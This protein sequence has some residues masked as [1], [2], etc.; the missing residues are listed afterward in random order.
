MAN[1]NCKMCGGSIHYNV[2]DKVVTCDFCGSTQ[3]IS[4]ITD[5]RKINLFNRANALRLKNEFD[6]ALATY[7][8]ILLEFPDDAEAHWGLCLCKYG[9]EYVNDPKT[10]KKIPTCHRTLYEN[11]LD[12][13]DYKEAIKNSDVVSRE[14]YESEAKT[15]DSIQKR[16]I[17][18]SQR[19]EPYDIFICYKETDENGQR[20]TDSVM[21]QDI[22]TELTKKGYKVFFSRI[23][24]EG[25]IGTEY[26]P[27]IFAALRSS[28]VM[29]CIANKV[30]YFNSPWVKNE[31]SRYLSFMKDS[32]DKYLIPC[33][34]DIDAYEL[35]EEMM[36][37]QAQDMDKIGAIQDLLRGIDKL[38]N[39][40]TIITEVK[41]TNTTITNVNISALLRRSEML[42]S[43]K[44]YKKAN[45][46]L[47]EVLNNDP[48]N[49]KAYGLLATIDLGFEK[50]S[51]LA[52]A[53][54]PL[55]NNNNYKYALKFADEDYKSQLK[56]YNDII[57]QRIKY[58][59]DL[60]IYQNAISYKE[61]GKY[62]NA[63]SFFEKVI[64]FK[65]SKEQIEMCN[66][67]IFERNNNTYNKACTLLEEYKYSE[68]IELFEKI[69]AF[70]DAKKQFEI[71]KELFEKEKIY[72]KSV[73][74]AS[75]DRIPYYEKAISSLKTIIDYRD[76]GL[77]VNTYEK[78]IDELKDELE[79]KRIKKK[80]RTRIFAIATASLVLMILLSYFIIIPGT[81][82][83]IATNDI[84]KG[85]YE[86][87]EQILGTIATF[88]DSKKQISLNKAAVE[89]EHNNYKEALEA[90]EKADGSIIV[91]YNTLGGNQIDDVTC[92]SSTDYDKSYSLEA[93]KA[94][95]IFEGW[96]IQEY[97]V[98][99][100]KR[101]INLILSANYSLINYDIN[102]DLESGSFSDTDDIIY[103]YDVESNV[104]IPN[105]IRVGY[106]FIG[107]KIND[108]KET[109]I[110]YTIQAGTCDNQSLKAIWRAN[111][112]TLTY[113]P[114]GGIIDASELIVDYDSNFTTLIPTREGYS[115]GGWYYNGSQI[116]SGIWN[117]E[118]N[119]TLTARWTTDEFLINYDLNGGI[120][121]SNNASQYTVEDE[122]IISSPSKKGYTFI[123]WTTLGQNTPIIETKIEKGS[124]GD[125]TY[126]ANWQAN[127]YT[128]SFNVN[129]NDVATIES[130]NVIF[131][132][133][134][135]L[136]A[137]NRTGYIFDG[138][139]NGNQKVETG[140]WKKAENLTLTAKWQVITYTISYNLDGGS[141]NNL[142]R[143]NYTVEDAFS[144]NVPEKEGY[145]FLG[146]T[147]SNNNNLQSTISISKGTIGNIIVSANWSANTYNCNL[148]VNS[149][150]ELVN[151]KFSFTFDDTYTLPEPTKTGYVFSGWYNGDNKVIGSTWKIA[152]N[153]TLIAS[154]TPRND[155]QYV[156]NHFKQNIIDDEFEL[157][158][159]CILYGVA[160]SNIKALT[161]DYFG[162][163]IPEANDV[164]VKADGSLVVDY[165][166][167]RKSYSISFVCNGGSNISTKTL[168][169]ETSLNQFLTSR[170]DY[171][172]G[173][174]YSDINLSN[175]VNSIDERVA[176]S[177][178]IYAWWKE[179]TK[180]KSFNYDL[181]GNEYTITGFNGTENHVTIPTYIDDKKVSRINNVSST[182]ITELIIPN[183]IINIDKGSLLCNNLEKL[184]TPFTGKERYSSTNEDQNYLNYAIGYMFGENSFYGGVETNQN[185]AGGSISYYL[186]SSLSEVI[187]ADSE[188]ITACSFLNC[189]YIKS[190]TITN[191]TQ[192]I[193]GVTFGGC[194]SLEKL[195]IPFI[196]NHALDEEIVFGSP[197]GSLFGY[198]TYIEGQEITQ[199]YYNQNTSSST[200]SKFKI[201]ST[202]KEITITGD[203]N[204]VSCAFYNCNMIEKVH[205]LGS[206]KRIGQN[207]FYG[208]TCLTSIDLPSDLEWIYQ[209]CF[210]NCSSLNNLSLPSA[211][212]HLQNRAFFGCKSLES[213]EL[214]EDITNISAS[215]FYDCISLKKMV[216]HGNITSVETNAFTNCKLDNVTAPAIVINALYKASL[217]EVELISYDGII[218]EDTFASCGNLIRIVIPESVTYIGVRAFSG[219]SLLENIELPSGLKTIGDAAF[220]RCS[221]LV[222]IDI[223]DSVKTIGTNVFSECANLSKMRLPFIGGQ[224]NQSDVKSPFGYIFGTSNANSSDSVSQE[225]YANGHIVSGIFNIPNS[226][227]EVIITNT[228]NIPYGAFSGCFN[229]ESISI[230][231]EIATIEN[232]AF[233]GCESLTN[234]IIPNSITYIGT[235]AFEN[236][237]SLSSI[238][239][240]NNVISIGDEA[241]KNCES[242][243]EVS[244]PDSLMLLGANVFHNCK[245]LTYVHLSDNLKT[246]SQR[247]F[248]QCES[249]T[250]I[251]LNYV[252]NI[253]GY[254]F[255]GCT[256]LTDIN[257]ESVN[258]IYAFAF[259]GCESLV[260]VIAEDAISVEENA[261]NNCYRLVR[262]VAPKAQVNSNLFYNCSKMT[263][264]SIGS[265]S[266]SGVFALFY[267]FGKDNSTSDDDWISDMTQ[268]NSLGGSQNWPRGY[269]PQSLIAVEFDRIPLGS[270]D[271]PWKYSCLNTVLIVCNEKEQSINSTTIVSHLLYNGT[272]S[273]Y[274]TLFINNGTVRHVYYYSEEK[275]AENAINYWHY[276]SDEIP[277]LYSDN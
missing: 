15:I 198:S 104:H 277:E 47:D 35:P 195:S 10:G 140:I 37:F 168:K 246:I 186:P 210:E 72:L 255:S 190:I 95:Y 270:Y 241:F 120:N 259:S 265:Y 191:N 216:V 249:L 26:E 98:T 151:D 220:N 239:M 275:P 243:A 267:L 201:P 28:K 197:L 11:I 223:P 22:Y 91:S 242:L 171:S 57:I 203:G 272:Q 114:N 21:A 154:W 217:K 94:G 139:Y 180:T 90:I 97:D 158:E 112:Y 24:L 273:E 117:F 56:K 228:D 225:F 268:D 42:I 69:L 17:E 85:N 119:I 36:A 160:D 141:N 147:S 41:Q 48:E 103:N 205:I 5:E 232:K 111:S 258:K 196:G 159:I 244:M 252:E 134:Y 125:I 149:G 34:R 88:S 7:E 50:E 133:A 52:K 63:I 122:V 172:F 167:L 9:I 76:S 118:S 101:A 182:N 124:V 128:L 83:L 136:P 78:R 178:K 266:G 233:Y 222:S 212:N 86:A 61:S 54:E 105:P 185:Y 107:W 173:G 211:V 262:F 29:L 187:V 38:F 192:T 80:K 129:C 93:E 2:G 165:Y 121:N 176:E 229:I 237:K 77:L 256:K 123:G 73:K 87:A 152:D 32:N 161:M 75:L 227:K 108:S 175:E 138:W 274:E 64:E 60:S 135:T 144:I 253:E 1:F 67:L 31:W 6:K 145:S 207:A 157:S 188:T 96:N 143:V 55:T 49:A 13:L 184:V 74:E 33:Y 44:N 40:L 19:E 39:R 215:L 16:I 115:F 53:K 257:L 264:I 79:A 102:Y 250:D 58:N 100:S 251:N 46:L 51:D 59:I 20:T 68:A 199:T 18:T 65:D 156:I 110:D 126:V 179:E 113:N 66:K 240:P 127:T 148:N 209:N 218:P 99:T 27:I 146:W 3:T 170:D 260:E 269:I 153:V 234:I 23:T 155:I 81:K 106:T 194:T 245:N 132:Q 12:D 92:T 130:S 248:S 236:C 219:C 263:Y 200:S 142:N 183:S 230:L 4:S 162:F 82:Y 163:D 181:V 276:N 189:K 221:S 235:S 213:I 174:W 271:Q 109:G 226:L 208:C 62:D 71:A 164:I 224:V 206:T 169:Y 43:D 84:K 193:S 70:K 202:L 131:D 177:L 214:P 30:D 137:P 238:K 254:A 150:D 204:V 8:T 89:L 25:K 116:V 14:V 166:Y 247:A 231:S 45:E 261:F